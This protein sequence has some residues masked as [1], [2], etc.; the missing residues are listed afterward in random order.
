MEELFDSTRLLSEPKALRDTLLRDGYIFLRGVMAKEDIEAAYAAVNKF[1][2]PLDLTSCAELLRYDAD[3]RL[4][5]AP[6]YKRALA[7]E[8]FNKL[9][10]SKALCRIVDYLVGR[11]TFCYPSKVLRVAPPSRARFLPG[12]LIHHDVAY[13]GVSDMITAWVPL[14][15]IPPS[16]G[17]LAILHASHLGPPHDLRPLMHGEP[18]WRT[19]HYEVGDVLLF[20]AFTAHASLPNMSDRVRVSGDFRWQAKEDPAPANLVIDSDGSEIFSEC[21]RGKAWWVSLP[22]GLEL[23]DCNADC[24][25]RPHPS[26]LFSIHAAW[27]N[28]VNPRRG[29]V[30]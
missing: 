28:W 22:D 25:V 16:L 1:V 4:H 26:R 15:S 2:G 21:F 12:R 24:L 5:T 6:A 23:L 17:G 27:G 7:T 13:W 9:P 20:H 19:T 8:E 11:P 10:Y 18:G 3:Y 14:M 29:L 30:K